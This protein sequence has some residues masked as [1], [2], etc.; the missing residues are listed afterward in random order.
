MKTVVEIE[1]FENDQI[2]ELAIFHDNQVLQ[3]HVKPPKTRLKPSSRDRWLTENLHGLV[4]SSGKVAYE[5]FMNDVL[6]HLEGVD[7]VYT[8]GKQKTEL[9]QRLLPKKTVKNL[10]DFGCLKIS[11]QPYRGPY[12]ECE[13]RAYAFHPTS[14]HC[15]VRKAHVF[16]KWINNL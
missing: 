2:K 10:E 7:T 12:P 16:G 15:A 9:L 11:R 1:C 3:F 8:K 13:A 14:F 5:E 4:Y 6:L